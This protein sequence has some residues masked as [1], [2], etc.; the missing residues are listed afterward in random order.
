MRNGLSSTSSVL[1]TLGVTVIVASGREK[2]GMILAFQLLSI[3]T[4]NICYYVDMTIVCYTWLCFQL[5]CTFIVE[6]TK[7]RLNLLN[8]IRDSKGLEKHNGHIDFL[9]IINQQHIHEYIITIPSTYT[10]GH[11]IAWITNKDRVN[12]QL[13][14]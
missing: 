10:I 6:K 1:E 12:T 13:T 5:I 11:K 7:C 8:I 14:N 3:A 4:D 9:L 2:K